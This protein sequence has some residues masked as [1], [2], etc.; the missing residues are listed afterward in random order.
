L[1]FGTFPHMGW[2]FAAP[3]SSAMMSETKT[4]AELVQNAHASYRKK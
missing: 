4:K 3:D 2:R 1:A